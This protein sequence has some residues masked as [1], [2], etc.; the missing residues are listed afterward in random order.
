MRITTILILFF[1][2]QPFANAQSFEG[3]IEY[4]TESFDATPSDLRVNTTMH[5]KNSNVR[6]KN[7]IAF[8]DFD[9]LRYTLLIGDEYYFVNPLG[10]E[11]K[12]DI[13]NDRGERHF[14]SRHESFKQTRKKEKEVL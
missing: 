7:L 8:I 13:S 11:I 10:N 4:Y 9:T 5:I 6:I 1:C 14:D 3:I 12:K 2:T